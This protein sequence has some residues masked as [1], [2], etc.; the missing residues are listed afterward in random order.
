VPAEG[1]PSLHDLRITRTDLAHLGASPH[2]EAVAWRWARMR[3]KAG[4][5][6]TP[7]DS[8]DGAGGT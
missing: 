1:S 2:P 8:A 7:D 4:P 3:P 6:H 5:A